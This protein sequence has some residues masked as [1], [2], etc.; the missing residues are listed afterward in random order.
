MEAI[1]DAHPGAKTLAERARKGD[2]EAFDALVHAFGEEIERHAGRRIG[3]HLRSRVEVDDILQE[4][5]A[6]AWKALPGFQWTGERAFLAWL[7]T[8]CEHVILKLARHHGRD[9]IIYRPQDRASDEPTPSRDLRREERRDRLEEALD[10]LG[11]DYREAVRLVR[12][13]GLQIRE[14]AARMNR[15]PKS[16]MHLVSRG[17]KKL[18][19][20]FGDTESLH[21]PSR[22]LEGPGGRHEDA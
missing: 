15:T 16:V 5:L 2:R 6:R 14:A 22:P 8:I 17:L 21:L 19:E 11:L 20:S 4:T 1:M 7:K 12:L 18:R 13:E 3:E 10:D 9:T